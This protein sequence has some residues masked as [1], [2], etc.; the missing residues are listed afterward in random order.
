[1]HNSFLLDAYI[2]ITAYKTPDEIIKHITEEQ[3]ESII[4]NP[5]WKTK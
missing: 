5:L 1:M 4:A 3:I 2:K